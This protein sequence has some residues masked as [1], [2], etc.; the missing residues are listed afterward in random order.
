M[1]ATYQE[2]IPKEGSSKVGDKMRGVYYWEEI[3]TAA[4]LKAPNNAISEMLR[5]LFIHWVQ[6]GNKH[7]SVLQLLA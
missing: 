2:N 6:L 3:F 1:L 4:E 7:I 5:R